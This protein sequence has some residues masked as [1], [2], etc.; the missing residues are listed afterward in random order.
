[1][2][3]A[4]CLLL[5]ASAAGFTGKWTGT[6]ESKPGEPHP[7]TLV[8]KQDGDKVE[9]HMLSQSGNPIPLA[10]GKV[11][12]NVLTIELH[13][14]QQVVRFRLELSGDRLDGTAVSETQT[15]QVQVHLTRTAQ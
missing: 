7:L 12:G 4:A 1:M 8:L 5:L 10:E 6:A 14:S 3:L 9:G 15:Q 2:R 13:G 11:Q